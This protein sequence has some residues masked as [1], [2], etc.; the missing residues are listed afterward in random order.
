[1]QL[2]GVVLAIK[3]RFLISFTH[4]GQFRRWSGLTFLPRTRDTF[5]S[6]PI[7]ATSQTQTFESILNNMTIAEI[8]EICLAFPGATEDIKWG[9]HLCFNIGG[10]MF[11]ITSPDSVPVSASFKTSP[12]DF[13]ALSDK[14]G[15]MPAPYL[16]RNK[17]VYVDTINCFSKK[18]WEKYLKLSY[19]IIASRLPLR[20][21]KE[22][23]S[24]KSIGKPAPKKKKAVSKKKSVQKKKVVRK[25]K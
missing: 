18:E 13:D 6:P 11:I 4:G 23:A 19:S 5:L 24:S 20:M 9:E 21:Q 15:F 3:I 7:P 14:E 8:R 12:E 1:M 25:K 10:K 22:I 16:A 2:R 17:W